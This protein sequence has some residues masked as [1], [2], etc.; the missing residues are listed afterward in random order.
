MN[1]NVNPYKQAAINAAKRKKD[2]LEHQKRDS[3]LSTEALE[4]Q[5]KQ[6]YIDAITSSR[7]DTH[8]MQ[9]SFYSRKN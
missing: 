2:Q 5:Q 3:L 1:F 8:S 7:C 4:V 6:Q 9:A